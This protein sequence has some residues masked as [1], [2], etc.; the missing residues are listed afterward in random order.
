MGQGRWTGTVEELT[1]TMNGAL[2]LGLTSQYGMKKA[3][4]LPATIRKLSVHQ[5]PAV[6]LYIYILTENVV[7]GG[8]IYQSNI[9]HIRGPLHY[10]APKLFRGYLNCLVVAATYF[11]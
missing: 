3:I 11:R 1:S 9:L 6:A 4:T 7:S 10:L 5:A 2:S 8:S